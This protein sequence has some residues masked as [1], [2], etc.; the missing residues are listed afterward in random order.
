[1]GQRWTKKEIA[2]LL[3]GV[4]SYGF[5]WF[6]NQTN[7]GYDWVGAPKSRSLAALYAKLRR[8]GGAGGFTRGVFTLR[9]MLVLTGYSR[10]QILRA[11]RALGQK[12]KRLRVHGAYL[13][14][15]E[16]MDDITGWLQHDYWAPQ[17]RLYAC[18]WCTSDKS[19]PYALGL[20]CPCYYQYRRFCLALELPVRVGDQLRLLDQASGLDVYGKILDNARSR[21][22]A[23]RALAQSQLE[24]LASV[25]K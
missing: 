14:T 7:P 2:M 15:D 16:Q 21:L 3:D 8:E 19:R 13:I 12:W 4:G 20:C 11:Q 25:V 22:E 24:W 1:M 18:L 6:Q 17:H 23:G 9:E 10:S 5:I